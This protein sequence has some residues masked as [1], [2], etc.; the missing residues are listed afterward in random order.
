MQ[1]KYFSEQKN[2]FFFV[3]INQFLRPGLGYDK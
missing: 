1:K 2:I 3:V